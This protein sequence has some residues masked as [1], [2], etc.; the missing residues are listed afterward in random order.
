MPLQVPGLAVRVSPSRGVP[1]IV[2]GAVSP[3]ADGFTEAGADAASALPAAFVAVQA[4]LALEKT[5]AEAAIAFEER[6]QAGEIALAEKQ[7][8]LDKQ[9]LI[10]ES[11]LRTREKQQA[12]L[13]GALAQGIEAGTVD[14]NGSA[15]TGN[16][17]VTL[18]TEL[19]AALKQL[20]APKRIV[21]DAQGRVS[22]VE[23]M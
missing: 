2:G 9:K 17:V 23:P 11:E 15:T 10:L 1:E 6:K 3:G 5:Q 14:A 13:G 16:A 18:V 22:H 4:H 8:E 7:F 21:R 12:A 19:A 20:S